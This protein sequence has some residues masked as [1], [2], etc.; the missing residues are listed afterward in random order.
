MCTCKSECQKPQELKG[1]PEECSLEQIEKCHGKGD[2]HPCV[3][4][5]TK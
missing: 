5:R 3:V 2:G 4:I 1:K